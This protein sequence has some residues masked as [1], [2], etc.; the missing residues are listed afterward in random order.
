MQYI[1]NKKLHQELLKFRIAYD[2][3]I[4]NG[5]EKP[6]YNDYIGRCI[7]DISERYATKAKFSGYSY[8]Q[9][10]KSDAIE[11]CIKY[12]HNFNP[13]MYK[14]PFAYITQIVHNAFIRRIQKEQK[15]QYIKMKLKQNHQLVSQLEDSTLIIDECDVAGSYVKDYEERQRLKKEEQQKKQKKGISKFVENEKE[16]DTSSD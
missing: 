12:L 7:L 1:S 3:A 11:D 6:R 5:T 10:M 13:Y 2:K 4:E 16:T 15:N 8:L 14:N 9:E